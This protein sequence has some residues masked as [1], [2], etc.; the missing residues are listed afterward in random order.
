MPSRFRVRSPHS[1][2]LIVLMCLACWL[3]PSIAFAAPS[4]NLSE[5]I[6]PPTS[7]ILVS[8]S[9]FAPNVGVDIYFDTKDEA[10]VVTNNEGEFHNAKIHAPSSAHPG[11]HWVTALERNNDKGDQEPFLV[12]TNWSQFHFDARTRLN[13]YENVL[14]PSTVNGLDLKWSY[15]TGNAV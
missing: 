8:G 2:F 4:I 7:Q 13:P 9:G 1:A 3:F 14:D 11:E 6:G 5:Q 10:L 15:L 12:N